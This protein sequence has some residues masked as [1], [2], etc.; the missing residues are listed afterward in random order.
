MI[1]NVLPFHSRP[2]FGLF[3]I[4]LFWNASLLF[5]AEP[6]ATPSPKPSEVKL[7]PVLRIFPNIYRTE[8]LR[9][10]E[11]KIQLR[12]ASV[13]NQTEAFLSEQELQNN[14]SPFLNNDIL[15][16]YGS[17]LSPRMGILG[18]WPRP[19]L[20]V[21]LDEW[22]EA[23]DRANGD[24]GVI[25]AFYLI[26]GTAWPEGEIGILKDEVLIPWIEYALEKNMLIYLDH[27]IGKYS[28]KEAVEALLPYLHYPNVHLALDPEWRT[29]KPMVEIGSVYAHELNEAQE[30]IENYLIE[31]GL[32]GERQLVVHQF[33]PI[34]IRKRNELRS[35]FFRVRLV[36]CADGFGGPALKRVSYKA[37]GEAKNLPVK[38]FKLFFKSPYPEAGYDDPLMS[39]EEVFKLEPRPYL[40]M[41]Q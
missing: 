29:L 35:D 22:A 9:D 10:S 33:K 8:W 2:I 38:G 5:S 41:Y 20:K 15:A 19:A 25:T 37:N 34:M 36:H 12:P 11:R 17:P 31:N 40:I 32:P 23:Y 24:R 3:F 28:V 7:S 39:P 1:R 27:Q 14:K 13:Q 30:I 6:G 26:Y 21:I 16:F 18:A 4:L